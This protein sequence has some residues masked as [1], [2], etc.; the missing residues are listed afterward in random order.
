MSP[1]EPVAAA[2]MFLGESFQFS[3]DF[4]DFSVV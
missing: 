3:G 2:F 1:V 4:G